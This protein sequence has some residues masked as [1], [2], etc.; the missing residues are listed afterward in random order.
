LDYRKFATARNIPDDE[1]VRIRECRENQ[2][3][4]WQV[5]E[6]FYNRARDPYVTAV[7]FVESCADVSRAWVVSD[8]VRQYRAA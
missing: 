7:F 4:P 5:S 8:L 2:W 6:G 1:Y 3:K